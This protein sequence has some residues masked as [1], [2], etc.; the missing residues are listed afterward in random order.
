VGLVRRRR[1][2]TLTQPD[3]GI[4]GEGERERDERRARD[5][6]VRAHCDSRRARTAL[7]VA[8]LIPSAV[9]ACTMQLSFARA[10]IGGTRRSG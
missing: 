10:Q 4:G 2:V 3:V 6:P 9:L 5:E 7:S 1:L 8:L